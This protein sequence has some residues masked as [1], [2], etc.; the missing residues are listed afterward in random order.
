MNLTIQPPRRP[1]NTIIAGIAGLARMTDKARAFKSDSFGDFKYGEDSG[2]DR[3]VLEFIGMQAGEFAD[4]AVEQSDDELSD[5]ALNRAQRSEQEIEDFNRE[6]IQREPEDELHVRLLNERLA[7]FAPDRTDIKTVFASI[8]LDDWGCFKDRDLTGHPPRSPYIRDVFHAVG[9]A[10]MADKA[11]ALTAGKLGEYRY[12][13]DSGL[14]RRILEFLGLDA[15]EFREA[16]YA[17]PNDCELSEW[18]VEKCGKKAR[19]ISVFNARQVDHGRYAEAFDRLEKRRAE[20][21]PE[22]S[23]IETF[24]DLIDFDDEQSFGMTDLSRHPPRS[25]FDE[26]VGGVAGLARMIDKFRALEGGTLGEFW[27]GEESGF[28]RMVLEFI[29]LSQSEFSK[30]LQERTGEGGLI[31]WL[32]EQLREKS[33]EE[34]GRFNTELLTLG[35]RNEQ[36][37]A[38]FRNAVNLLDPTRRELES[39][40]ALTVLD[41]QVSFARLKAG[42]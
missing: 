35:P 38:F 31:E 14:D 13:E 15:E 6:H 33:G 27:C 23:D 26:T 2:L 22:R 24:F 11:R 7:K 19:D 29:E 18:L 12:G 41:D 32:N 37:W 25:V 34:R 8:E 3:E 17:D 9:V 5:L 42:V 21:A 36:Q 1:S 4:A 16:A 10:R 40:A 20:I 30:A 28:D 39:W